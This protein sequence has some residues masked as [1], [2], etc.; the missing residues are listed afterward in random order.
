MQC[1]LL[2]L[3]GPRTISHSGT[4]VVVPQMIRFRISGGS[5]DLDLPVLQYS[6][7]R[8]MV[9]S[10][11]TFCRLL[12]DAPGDMRK[13]RFGVFF[14]H[15]REAFA[16]FQDLFGEVPPVVIREAVDAFCKILAVFCDVI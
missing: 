12:G 7:F 9:E 14:G 16:S 6:A 15:A 13:N 4:H 8:E 11:D 5:I 3:L 2:R 1:T 10:P